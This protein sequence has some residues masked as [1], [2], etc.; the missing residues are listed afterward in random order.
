MSFAACVMAC[1]V[2]VGAC[3]DDVDVR[4]E[5]GV[6]CARRP[7]LCGG[8]RPETPT[9]S[10]PVIVTPSGVMPDGVMSQVAHNNLDI[11]WHDGGDGG[12]LFFAFRTAPN[13]FAST[14]VVMYVVSTA[15]LTT[16]R[17]EGEFALGTDVREPQ[18]VSVGG[19]LL[20]YFVV[21]GADPLDFEPQGTRVARWLGPGEFEAPRDVFEP[22][23]LVWRIKPL[24][25]PG[26]P[27]GWLT[28]F[29]YSGG[30]N[31]Y[32]LDGE[33]IAVRWLKSRDGLVWEPVDATREVVLLGGASETDAVFMPDGRVVA[34]ARNEAGDASGFGSKVCVGER[35][36]SAEW[37]CTTDKK[38]YDSPLVFSQGG[39]AWLIGRRNISETGDYDLG[40][41]DKDMKDRYLANQLDYWGRPKR[42]ALWSID[43]DKRG[44]DHVL[45]LPSAGD[46]CF[47]EAVR[48]SGHEWLVFNYSSPTNLEEDPSWLDGQLGPTHIYWTV[49]TFP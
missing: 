23:F 36:A 35:G 17:K 5:A 33:P 7:G 20:F 11:A 19:T 16:W 47:P 44:V 31:I 46:T 3:A 9:L 18:L 39:A 30:E 27:D 1:A 6:L 22:G 32:D 34:V 41:V 29:G 37:S 45:D 38:K 10:A 8:A 2:V 12:R 13:H 40:E 26:Q 14:Q 49:L 25:G 42:C 48:L 4:P 43:P 21:L 15:D 28:A 24:V